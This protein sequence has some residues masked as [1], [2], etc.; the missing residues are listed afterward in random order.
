AHHDADGVART[1][2]SKHMTRE[3]ALALG[4]ELDADE[5]RVVHTAHFYPVEEA[6]EEPLAVDGEQYVL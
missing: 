2:G 3:G 6:F 4:E 5:T 1:F